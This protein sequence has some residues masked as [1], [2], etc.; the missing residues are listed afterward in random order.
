VDNVLALAVSLDELPAKPADL[1]ERFPK[2]YKPE[3]VVVTPDLAARVL[4]TARD[5]PI[6]AAAA[7]GLSGLRASEVLGARWPDI[8]EAPEQVTLSSNGACI[9]TPA[10][11]TCCRRRARCRGAASRSPACDRGAPAPAG[12]SGQ[13]APCP[14]WPV[15]HHRSRRRRR[16]RRDRGPMLNLAGHWGK[17]TREIGE[18][19]LR[20]HDRRHGC[21]SLMLKAAVNPKVLSEHL[22]HFSP[23]FTLATYGHL[24]PRDDA[25]AAA[26]LD[27]IV[28]G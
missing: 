11:S 2:V 7:L 25:A 21:A 17:L 14:W 3:L 22:G 9:R 18:P 28:S 24:M 1:V 26:A 13:A 12:R 19:K 16:G 15:A 20:F 6:D 5:T 23:A 4:D 10:A 8:H 27:T